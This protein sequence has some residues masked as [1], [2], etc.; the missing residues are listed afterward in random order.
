MRI[1]NTN[2]LWRDGECRHLIKTTHPWH[3]SL[4]AAGSSGSKERG[5]AAREQSYQGD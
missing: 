3:S 2:S 5:M 4:G 1:C